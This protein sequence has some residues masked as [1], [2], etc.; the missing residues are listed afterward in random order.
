MST[1]KRCFGVFPDE[2]DN[3]VMF[4]D[5]SVLTNG[6]FA[7]ELTVANDIQGLN[8]DLFDASQEWGSVSPCRAW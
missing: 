5:S 2:F 6:A 8:I 3:V 1:L 4:T 7:Y